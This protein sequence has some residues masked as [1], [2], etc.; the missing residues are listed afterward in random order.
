[1]GL[2]LRPDQTTIDACMEALAEFLREPTQQRLGAVVF[3]LQ[4]HQD[5]WIAERVNDQE[6][7]QHP[8]GRAG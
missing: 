1:M 2:N 6:R 8:P 5:R 4:D 3:K 7:A